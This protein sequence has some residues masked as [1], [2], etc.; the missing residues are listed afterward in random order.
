MVLT[1]TS[2]WYA[3]VPSKACCISTWIVTIT[4]RSLCSFRHVI[5]IE[6]RCRRRARHAERP[7]VCRRHAPVCGACRRPVGVLSLTSA[8]SQER[9]PIS[10]TPSTGARRRSRQ[11]WGMAAVGL[12]STHRPQHR[13][14]RTPTESTWL[15]RC[16][17]ERPGNH[18]VDDS[19][20]QHAGGSGVA[21]CCHAAAASDICSTKLRRAC[22]AV[23]WA[24]APRTVLAHP[25][26]GSCIL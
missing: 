16:A 3:Q 25:L 15:L 6:G 9:P 13:T 11:R 19:A 2:Y 5:A 22:T 20:F 23:R 14:A 10:V 7:P 8:H 17:Q 21:A 1:P 18:L 4:K 26:A 12:C 24:T